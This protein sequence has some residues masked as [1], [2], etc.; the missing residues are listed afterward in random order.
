MYDYPDD[1]TYDFPGSNWAT[2][3]INLTTENPEIFYLYAAQHYRVGELHIWKDCDYLYIEYDLDDGYNMSESHLHVAKSLDE[4]PQS[5]GNPVPGQFD[6]KEDHDPLV[7]EYT[8]NITWD[9]SWDC[10]ELYIAT[11]AVV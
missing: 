3:I 6:Y 7:S 4:I 1:F 9:S 10:I 2:Y 11:H 5:N 8:Y